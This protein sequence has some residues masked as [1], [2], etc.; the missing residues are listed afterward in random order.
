MSNVTQHCA[1]KSARRCRGTP[2]LT[3]TVNSAASGRLTRDEAAQLIRSAGA[4]DQRSGDAL[5][6]EFAGLIWAIAR[7]F[8]LRRADAA[9]VAQTTWLRLFEHLHELNEPGSVGAWLATTARRE[10]LRVLRYAQRHSLSGEH[11]PELESLDEQPG[12]ALLVA[13]RDRALWRSFARLHASDQA[14]L[15][16]LIADPRPAYDEI[17]AALE[18]PLG[19]IGP[20]RARALKRLQEE[21]EKDETLALLMA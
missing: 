2:N 17:S 7:A 18:M 1:P 5:V 4:G 15:A 8:G 13:E 6:R 10:C 9:D 19:S 16:L 14:L 3:P 12:D 21:L 11:A 20:T